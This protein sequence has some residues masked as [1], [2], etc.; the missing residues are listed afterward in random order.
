VP[1]KVVDADVGLNVTVAAVSTG[2][3][4]WSIVDA[5]DAPVAASVAVTVQ[6]PADVLE[7]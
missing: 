3:E 5:L 4:V 2:E 6:N 7:V 1:P